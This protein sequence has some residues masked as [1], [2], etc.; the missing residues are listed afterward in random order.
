MYI[1]TGPTDGT[2]PALTSTA[3]CIN[4]ADPTDLNDSVISGGNLKAGSG[5]ASITGEQSFPVADLTGWTVTASFAAGT[6]SL[7]AQ[8][9]CFDNP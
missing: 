5:A 6:A 8:A 4:P 9:I 3:T 2:V 1:V 7:T